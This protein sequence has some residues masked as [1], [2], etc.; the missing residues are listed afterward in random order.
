MAFH[1]V[2]L[3]KQVG[4]SDHR[5]FL[6]LVAN[7]AYG[8]SGLWE[9]HFGLEG[10]LGKK[11]TREAA[12]HFICLTNTD[13]TLGTSVK[14]SLQMHFKGVVRDFNALNESR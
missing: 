3:Q 8:N 4:C 9:Y 7:K 6:T 5:V 1:P 14:E 13:T 2:P 11:A 10:S 12:V